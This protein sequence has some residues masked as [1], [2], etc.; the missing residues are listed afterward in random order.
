M[1]AA[2][3]NVYQFR[4]T[5]KD[6]LPRVYRQILVPEDSN[7][8][9]LHMAITD[10]MGWKDCHL[11]KF[12]VRNPMNYANQIIGEPMEGQLDEKIIKIA[13]Y[14]Y[15]V[16][17]ACNHEYDFGDGWEHRVMLEKVL[18]AKPNAKYPQCINGKRACP[19]EDCGGPSGFEDFLTAIADPN[20]AEHK[21][22]LEW[23]GGQFD[24]AE[25]DH[26][27]VVFRSKGKE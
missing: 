4:V 24:P 5:L 20:H 16:K 19:P 10:A 8:H 15:K 12:V 3:S 25:F 1:A 13:S 2:K 23:C 11:H 14:F 6:T 17:D 21:E 9:D 18:P 22:K 26:K 7:F 27:A